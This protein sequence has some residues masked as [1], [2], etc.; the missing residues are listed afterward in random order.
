VLSF[1]V[2][3]PVPLRQWLEVW[4]S[5][6]SGPADLHAL[7][8]CR[9]WAPELLGDDLV[10]GWSDTINVTA[11]LKRWIREDARPRLVRVKADLDFIEICA[12]LESGD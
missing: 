7:D 2:T 6:P 12:L 8:L 10:L 9:W 11:D 1:L 5:Q 4:N 3:I